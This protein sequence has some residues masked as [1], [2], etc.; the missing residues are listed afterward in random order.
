MTDPN[1][2]NDPIDPNDPE[3]RMARFKLILPDNPES[4]DELRLMFSFPSAGVHLRLMWPDANR[5]EV[6]NLL[7]YAKPLLE[8]CHLEYEVAKEATEIDTDLTNLFPDD[9]EEK[10]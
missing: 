3:G 8:K 9:L 5:K 1:N 2:P 4:S 6:L 10:P 7:E